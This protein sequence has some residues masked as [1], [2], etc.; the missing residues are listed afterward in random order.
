MKAAAAVIAA[1]VMTVQQD[2]EDSEQQ[3]I[4]QYLDSHVTTRWEDLLK[5]LEIG[6][7]KY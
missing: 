5:K 4:D 7:G 2:L 6:G 3:C 1:L